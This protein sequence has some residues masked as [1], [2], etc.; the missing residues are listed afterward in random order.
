MNHGCEGRGLEVEGGQDG[1]HPWETMTFN[2]LSSE[3]IK[4]LVFLTFI[5][6]YLCL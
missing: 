1:G 6:T 5:A 2:G 3:V 4:S